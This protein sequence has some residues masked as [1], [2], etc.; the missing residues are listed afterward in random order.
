MNDT[1]QTCQKYS[2]S[3]VY[4]SPSNAGPFRGETE[5]DYK[6]AI[7]DHIYATFG[8]AIVKTVSKVKE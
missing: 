2:V 6:P 7:G 1:K 5:L 3:Y 8:R 4:I